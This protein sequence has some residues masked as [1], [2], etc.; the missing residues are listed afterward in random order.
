MQL[1][2]QAL[3]ILA[4]ITLENKAPYMHT[5]THTLTD[6]TRVPEYK[7]KAGR[8]YWIGN[9]EHSILRAIMIKALCKMPCNIALNKQLE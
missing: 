3:L 6:R 4:H 1:S 8:H 2:T 5:Y 7:T 9:G